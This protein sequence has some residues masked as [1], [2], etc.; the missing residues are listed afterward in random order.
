MEGLRASRRDDRTLPAGDAER[1]RRPQRPR[2]SRRPGGPQRNP[3]RAN[4]RCLPQVPGVR[5]A[6]REEPPLHADAQDYG[7][8]PHPDAARQRDVVLWPVGTCL[9]RAGGQLKHPVRAAGSSRGRQGGG[10]RAR[11]GVAKEQGA[12]YQHAA[13]RRRLD[14]HSHLADPP[15]GAILRVDDHRGPCKPVHLRFEAA[16]RREEGL[17][18]RRLSRLRQIR[19]A[20]F[21]RQGARVARRQ[22]HRQRKPRKASELGALLPLRAGARGDDLRDAPFRQ[23]RLV[24]SGRGAACVNAAW[25]R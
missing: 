7:E 24:P 6:R 12:L 25:R 5:R 10:Q 3:R 18:R 22:L 16:G 15:G 2:R 17:P 23:E 19:P 21:P 20:P 13:S 9:V 8:V 1:R 4:L 11:V 14:V